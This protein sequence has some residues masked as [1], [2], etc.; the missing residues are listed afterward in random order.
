[1]PDTSLYRYDA[2]VHIERTPQDRATLLQMSEQLLSVYQS[3]ASSRMRICRQF[4]GFR[5]IEAA[6]ASAI[7]HIHV[8]DPFLR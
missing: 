1:M 6:A 3:H 5:S 8:S 4:P 7:H 2:S